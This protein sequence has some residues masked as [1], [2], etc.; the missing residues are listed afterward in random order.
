MYI[1][2]A[3][4]SVLFVLLVFESKP[5][6]AIPIGVFG[7]II[8]TYSCGFFDILRVQ[9]LCMMLMMLVGAVCLLYLK[10]KGKLLRVDYKSVLKCFGVLII[11]IIGLGFFFKGYT[12]LANGSYN[13]YASIVKYLWCTDSLIGA[14]SACWRFAYYQ[15]AIGLWHYFVNKCFG[16]YEEWHLFFSYVL[17]CYICLL[18]LIGSEDEKNKK[19][20]IP[21]VLNYIIY[22]IFPWA[23]GSTAISLHLAV[24]FA[25]AMIFAFTLWYIL[26]YDGAGTKRGFDFGVILCVG[27]LG[28]SKSPAI[29]FAII[30]LLIYS[31]KRKAK[32]LRV[33][34]VWGAGLAGIFS[35]ELFVK[36]IAK[37][38]AGTFEGGAI[39]SFPPYTGSTVFRYIKMLFTEPVN[40]DRGITVMMV[41]GIILVILVLN[42]YGKRKLSRENRICAFVLGIGG[43][44]FCFGHLWMYLFEFTEAETMVMSSYARYLTMYI[45]PI[46]FVII[47][48]VI[49]KR[50]IAVEICIAILLL[51]SVPYGVMIHRDSVHADY[52]MYSSIRD[53]G[54]AIADDLN[55]YVETGETVCVLYDT[56][57]HWLLPGSLKYQMIP[58]TVD[59]VKNVSDAMFMGTVC[60]Y[61]KSFY[62]TIDEELGSVRLYRVFL[63]GQEIIY[64]PI[65][66]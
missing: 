58:K 32:V 43:I 61:E 15:P 12:V 50:L 57:V 30:C 66:E 52:E 21:K 23:L 27:S 47:M 2:F 59:M 20:A 28:L 51:V 44:L 34:L 29:L 22:A 55:K 48:Y 37:Y 10:H 39:E 63:N 16:Q 45:V 7:G 62:L 60:S 33:A 64:T 24:D 6:R 9:P 8:V 53:E 17:L 31:I 56:E 65:D 38:P 46:L 49:E 40:A 14:E 35:W 13:Y 18:P 3:L 26:S 5:E 54:I 36:Y 41:V 4:F 1:I 11:V 25:T 42:I 19:S